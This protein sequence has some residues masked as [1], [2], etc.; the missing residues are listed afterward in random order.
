MV[1]VWGTFASARIVSSRKIK[2]NRSDKLKILDPH[3]APTLRSFGGDQLVDTRALRF[4]ST[5]YCSVVALPSLTSWVHC[6]AAS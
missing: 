2:G 4:F 6:S 3:W 5:K 1:L